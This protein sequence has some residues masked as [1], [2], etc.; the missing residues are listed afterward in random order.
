MPKPKLERVAMIAEVIAAIAVV[1]SV[2][3]LA[4][5]I[6]ANNKLMQSQT[7]HNFLT[8]GHPLQQMV[9]SNPEFATLII[10][11]DTEPYSVSSIK[12]RRCETYYQM[13]F[14][15][16]EYLY[17]QNEDGIVEPAFWGGTEQYYANI[18]A[19]RGGYQRF[20][21]EWSDIY[22]DPFGAHASTIIPDIQPP[23]QNEEADQ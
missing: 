23:Q 15:I 17:Y 14:D 19:A 20:W 22:K 9:A 21:R 7:Y 5:Q 3:Y 8:I 18:T 2:I 16:W 6:S 12:W 1:I 13:S 10:E 4:Q 11:C